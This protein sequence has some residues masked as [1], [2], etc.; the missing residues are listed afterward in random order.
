MVSDGF[1]RLGGSWVVGVGLKGN[2][3]VYDVGRRSLGIGNWNEV[4]RRRKILGRYSLSYLD[5]RVKG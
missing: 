5:V 3:V 2:S 1:G 4:G